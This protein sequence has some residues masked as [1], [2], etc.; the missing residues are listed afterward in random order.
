M[1]TQERP[2]PQPLTDDEMDALL[3]RQRF[4]VLATVKRSGHPHLSTVAYRWDD[5]VVRVS[6]TADRLKARQVRADPRSALHVSPDPWSFVV[7]EGE[8]EVSEVTTERGDA[9][10]RE[11]LSLTPGFADSAEERAF[12]E[13]LVRERRV[14]LRLRATRRYGTKL[15]PPA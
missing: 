1:S 10:G 14:V 9:V 7:V 3:T 12:L 15:V 8:A 6:T 5:G 13:E 4:G 2:A 11:L